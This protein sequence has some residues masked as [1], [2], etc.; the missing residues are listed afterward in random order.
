MFIRWSCHRLHS[1]VQVD[2]FYK[3]VFGE[4]ARETVM[5]ALGKAVSVEE[6]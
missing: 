3:S 5:A 1:D 4:T 2:D 6:V